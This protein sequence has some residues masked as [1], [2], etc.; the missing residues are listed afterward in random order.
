[1]FRNIVSLACVDPALEFLSS[2]AYRVGRERFA[3]IP[4]DLTPLV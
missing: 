3:L 2:R 1:M 4:R